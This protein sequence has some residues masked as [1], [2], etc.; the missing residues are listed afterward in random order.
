M[1]IGTIAE[2]S[3]EF[4]FLWA[5]FMLVIYSTRVQRSVQDFFLE[6]KWKTLTIALLLYLLLWGTEI[7]LIFPRKN[8][9]T[10]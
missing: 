9:F 1:G 7:F 4:Y 2:K 10:P 6:Q 8:I 5:V 3:D